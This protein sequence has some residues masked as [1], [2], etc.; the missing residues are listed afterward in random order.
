MRGSARSMK[1]CGAAGLA[2]VMTLGL[3][4]TLTSS[5][6][7]SAPVASIAT[8]GASSATSAT[9]GPPATRRAAVKRL[10]VGKLPSIRVRP[11]ARRVVLNG[12][13][14]PRAARLV[15]QRAKPRSS[16]WNRVKQVRSRKRSYRT[17]VPRLKRPMRYRVVDR[18]RARRSFARLVRPPAT[19]QT[20]ACGV[21]PRKADGSLWSCTFVDNF[22]G[23]ELDRD[24]WVPQTAGYRTGVDSDRYAC[25]T[26]DNV[27]VRD[28]R[29]R[30]RLRKQARAVEC[31]KDSEMLEPTHY[32]AGSVSTYHRF[33]QRYGRFEARM[34]NTA[35][36]V[37]GLHEAFWLWPDD[38][39]VPINWPLSGEID[40]AETYSSFPRLAIPFLHYANPESNPLDPGVTRGPHAN[41]AYCPAER[42]TWNTYRLEWGPERIRIFVN[43]RLCLTNTSGDAAFREKYILAFTQAIGSKGN[44]ATDATPIPAFTEVDWVRAWR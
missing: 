6:V 9:A 1:F 25:Y 18:R 28:G 20:D 23:N 5:P 2:G 44:E 37:P 10:R 11:R 36:T 32:T 29:L 41:T 27:A 35:A 7:G 15:V 3:A 21:R 39:E 17:T 22:S 16:R 42:G 13:T 30:L 33:S 19:V 12:R 34:R 4:A 31:A 43:D 38:R 26:E 40:V 8:A 24:T 14:R